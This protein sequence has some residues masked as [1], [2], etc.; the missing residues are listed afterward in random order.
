MSRRSR[1]GSKQEEQEEDDKIYSK[2]EINNLLMS[3]FYS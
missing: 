1:K 3:I 2:S